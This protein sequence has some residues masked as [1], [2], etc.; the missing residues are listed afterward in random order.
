MEIR[1]LTQGDFY[2]LRTLLDQVFTKHNGKPASFAQIFP[3]L[4]GKENSFAP[5]SHLGAF[6]DG[7]LVGTAAMYPID[8][9]VGGKHIRL[10]ANGN[11]AVDEAYRGRG[12]MGAMLEEINR[13][14]DRCGDLCYLHGNAVRYGRFGYVAD[15]VEYRLTVNPGKEDIFSFRPMEQADVSAL[16]RLS[17]QKPDYVV[18]RDEDFI[19]A[20][21]SGGREAITV[22][23]GEG[24][25]AG[26]LSLHRGKAHIEEYAFCSD[27]ET[28]IFPQIACFVE[29]PITVTISGY[30]PS[31][32]ERCKAV[33]VVQQKNP[34]LF[35][36]I[37]PEV[38][39]EAAAA[40]GL[41]PVVLCAPYLT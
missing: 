34:A 38:L 22:L 16:N 35:R 5:E 29:R 7:K 24:Q 17:R 23:D 21:R 40:L 27:W 2:E 10:I 33:A 4:F 28:R 25:P 9:V 41:D 3:R 37:H 18:R 6:V 20:L 12:I 39:Q 32:A 31:A 13:E 26:Y 36:R 15:G 11:V 8:Y 30:D 1:H 14:C 19:A